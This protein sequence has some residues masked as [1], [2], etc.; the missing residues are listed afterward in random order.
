MARRSTWFDRVPDILAELEKPTAAPFFDR[1]AIEGLF[2]LKRRQ[3]ID[4]MKKLKRYP[5][6]KA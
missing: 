5:I 6:A 1:E 2:G 3:S 4:L